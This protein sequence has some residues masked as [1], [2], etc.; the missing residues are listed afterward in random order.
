MELHFRHDSPCYIARPTPN[1]FTPTTALILNDARLKQ[2][3]PP[4]DVIAINKEMSTHPPDIVDW[5]T[6]SAPLHTEK[7]GDRAR[8][9]G[10][11][12]VVER[13]EPE[14]FPPYDCVCYT[15]RPLPPG[16][17]WQTTVLNTTTK[18]WGVGL[19]SGCVLCLLYHLV[20][21]M[22]IYQ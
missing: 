9:T 3:P 2:G 13:W 22:Y 7:H 14:Q 1:S 19:V 20:M 15:S 16:Q 18:R 8:F 12:C 10:E 17:V 6:T 4:H 21:S 11:N 5:L